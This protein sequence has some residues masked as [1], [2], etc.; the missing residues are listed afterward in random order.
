MNESEEMKQKK[1]YRKCKREKIALIT[2]ANTLYLVILHSN[3]S[4]YQIPVQ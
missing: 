1:V 2:T 4:H 3:P